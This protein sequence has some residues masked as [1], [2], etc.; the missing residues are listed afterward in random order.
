M[1]T[2]AQIEQYT[3][4]QPGKITAHASLKELHGI[5]LF[6]HAHTGSSQVLQSPCDGGL[7]M[8]LAA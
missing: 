3:S 6:R 8:L 5:G 1:I 4:R 2:L 7:L